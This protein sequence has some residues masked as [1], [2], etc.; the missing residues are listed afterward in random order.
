MEITALYASLLA[1]LFILL[2][3]RVIGA[4]RSAKVPVG[5]GGNTI[6]LRRMRVH[7]NFA[8]YVPFA[9][10]LMALAENLGAWPWLIHLLGVTLVAGRLSHAHGVSQHPEV[11]RFRISGMAATLMVI[12]IAAAICLFGALQQ[13]FSP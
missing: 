5:D 12:G 7:A 4:R 11:F 6:L 10:L 3:V 9:L 2:S 1:P 8:E 13:I